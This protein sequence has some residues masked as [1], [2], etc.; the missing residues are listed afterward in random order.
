MHA[1]SLA[2]GQVL[3]LP[4]ARGVEIACDEG[5]VW[6]TEERGREDHWLREGESVRLAGRGL[7]VLEAT[8]AARIRIISPRVH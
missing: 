7:A 8:R 2:A 1:L 4:D 3:R 6:I 5:R